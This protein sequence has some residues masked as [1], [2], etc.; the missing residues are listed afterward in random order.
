VLFTCETTAAIVVHA[1]FP[2]GV[3]QK[4]GGH[5][6]PRPKTL[7]GADAAWDTRLP[8]FAVTCKTCRE[9]LTE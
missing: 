7:C 3:P 8:L 2:N 5:A 6:M 4:L 1:R 9:I